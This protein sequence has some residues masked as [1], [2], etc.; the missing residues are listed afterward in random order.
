MNNLPYL[1]IKSSRKLRKRLD[2]SL[3]EFD[4]TAAQF[5]VINQ[6]RMAQ[7]SVTA[8]EI[9]ERLES[10]RPTIS[11]I[12]TRLERKGLV[13][14]YDHPTDGRSAFV[15]VSEEAEALVTSITERSEELTEEIFSIYSEVEKGQLEQMILRL[16]E[17][18]EE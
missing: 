15:K 9:A 1:L 17:R 16:L 8:A 4:L 18:I 12:L 6:I 2:Q 7:T 14:K 11:G 10:D 3:L 13:E 5:S